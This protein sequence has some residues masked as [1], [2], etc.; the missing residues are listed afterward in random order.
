MACKVPI[1]SSFEGKK[2]N[3]LEVTF[4][5]HL[6]RLV[7]VNI[8][9]P[10]HCPFC[11]EWWYVFLVRFHLFSWAFSKNSLNS[12]NT[13]FKLLN[14]TIIISTVNQTNRNMSLSTPPNLNSYLSSNKK[15]K[16]KK[17]N[18]CKDE[19]LVTLLQV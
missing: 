4:E 8:L 15:K 6:A 10:F 2:N 16:I 18:S 12:K 17:I 13:Q 3:N 14:S 9:T 7:T 11:F 1:W 5:D 19:R